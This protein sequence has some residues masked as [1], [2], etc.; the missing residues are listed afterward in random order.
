MIHAAN[1]VCGWMTLKHRI[2]WLACPR[3]ASLEFLTLEIKQLAYIGS[4]GGQSIDSVYSWGSPFPLPTAQTINQTPAFYFCLICMGGNNF[5]ISVVVGDLYS[6]SIHWLNLIL[7]SRLCMVVCIYCH[8]KPSCS[9][10]ENCSELM[11]IAS[12]VDNHE[13]PHILEKSVKN[14]LIT[15]ISSSPPATRHI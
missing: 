8:S 7:I 4:E 11:N 13:E 10:Q 3:F 9:Y 5:F 6:I 12:F 1:F 15:F 14:N 2:R